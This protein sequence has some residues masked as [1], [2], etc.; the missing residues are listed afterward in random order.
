MSD[1]LSFR[2]PDDFVNTY[3]EKQPNW[4]FPMG[5]NGNS[6]GEIVFFNNYS[7]VKEDG[8]KERWHE[9]VRRVVEGYTSLLKDH[10][11]YYKTPWNEYKALATAKDAYDRMFQFKW[12]PPGRGIWAMGT[13]AVNGERNSAMLYNCAVLS[14]AKI[15]SHSAK[16]AVFPFVRL[17]EMSMNG[18]GVGFDTR[19]AGNLEIHA[20]SEDKEEVFVVPDSREGW[21]ESLGVLLESY[22]FENRAAVKFDYSQVRPSGTPL[23]RFGGTASGPGPL[24]ECHDTIVK[25]LNRDVGKPISSENIVDIMCVA[26]KAVQAGGSRRSALL[27]LGN[28]EDDDFINLKNYNEYQERNGMDGWANLSNNSVIAEVGGNYDHLA[29]RIADNGEPGILY[30]D[31]ARNYGRTGDA[32]DY[33]DQNIVGTNPCGEIFLE[34]SELC[35]L[36]E[37]FPMH[38][39]DINDFKRS[40]K[41]AYMYNKAVTLLPT[42]WP[43]TNEVINRNRRIGLSVSGTVQF[44]EKKSHP[45]YKNWLDEAYEEVLRRDEQYSAWLGIRESIRHTTS[46]PS[47]S[48][49]ILAGATPGVH[50][51][52]NT[53]YI[54]R[55]RMRHDAPI[56][57]V[58]KDA[59][60][61]VEPDVMDPSN[62]AVVELPT[63]G[64]EVRTEEEVSIWEKASV[65]ALV[66]KH[67]AD[68]AV[69][70]TVT[71]KQNEKNQIGA[72]L[73]AFE[74]QLK[75]ISFLPISEATTVYPQMPYEAISLDTYTK[76]T[77]DVKPLNWNSLYDGIDNDDALGDKFCTTDKCEIKL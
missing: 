21:A 41:H 50:W 49:S 76:L 57:Q 58:L 10:C 74:G 31:M 14:T 16:S 32:P 70:V 12:L 18:I 40:I 25:L 56:L 48:V 17:M 62:T 52:T 73:R 60:Y 30:L 38:H 69:S 71:F 33:R 36:S 5:D 11:L 27:A 28:P 2:L 19:G 9:T 59:G 4:G 42:P 72:V 8:T 29:D 55:M 47:G 51:P 6:L 13:E 61:K 39:D 77:E 7:R 46:K 75:S 22:F 35:N 67:F 20:P 37:L 53:I 34:S 15:S 26:A 68:N 44:L 65:A 24:M 1:F 63:C 66:Q 43:E 45:E 54:R 23:K 3:A 64:P